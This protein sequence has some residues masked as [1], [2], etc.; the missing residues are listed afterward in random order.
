MGRPSRNCIISFDGFNPRNAVTHILYECPP[1]PA[2]L[3][4]GG[5]RPQGRFRSFR[6][7][8]RLNPNPSSCL[9]GGPLDTACLYCMICHLISRVRWIA[10]PM[11]AQP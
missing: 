7:I 8:W 1:Y 2:W 5:T 10:I 3:Y 9:S 6:G 4:V 11:E